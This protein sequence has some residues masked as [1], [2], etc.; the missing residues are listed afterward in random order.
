MKYRQISKIQSTYVTGLLAE[1]AEDGR[2]HTRFLQTVARTG[3]LS[4]VAPNL[5]NI[6]IR[7]EEGRQ[8]R[9]AFTANHE[10]WKIF[11]SDYSQIELRVMAHISRDEHMTAAFKAGEDIHSATAARIFDLEDTDSVTPN[12][13][14]DA[15]MINFGIIYGMSDYGLSE[16]L[17]ITRKA[18]Q[19][20]IDIYFERY[21]GIKNYMDDIKREA[22]DK[23]Y[24]E[25]LFH[26]RRYLP[27]INARNFN[28]RTFAERT[29]I[30]TP[31]QGSAADIIKMAMIEM[32]THLK[33]EGLQAEMLLQ[34]HDELIFEV[35]SDEITQLND[36]VK[37][38]MENIVDLDVPLEIES[39]YGDNWYDTED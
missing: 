28:Q 16:S 8:I 20:F 5:Q 4:S 27:D 23:G 37:D 19:E 15:K 22:K 18:A 32:E 38:V 9:K 30:N 39:H 36:L 2:I 11:A 7:T 29:A 26:R 31:I 24:V 12:M 13:R 1:I 6:P 21:P 14:R 35:P 17:G 3:R 10:G 33:K 34:V 25:T